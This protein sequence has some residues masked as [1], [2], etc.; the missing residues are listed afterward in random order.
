M[1]LFFLV[2]FGLNIKRAA[3]LEAPLVYHYLA[4]FVKDVLQTLLVVS[5]DV[6]HKTSSSSGI[7]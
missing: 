1:N 4:Q 3:S 7:Y 6:D 5:V 2:F